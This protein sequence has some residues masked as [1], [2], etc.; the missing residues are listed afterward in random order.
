MRIQFE[1][2]SE[3]SKYDKVIY[4]DEINTSD[5]TSDDRKQLLSFYSKLFDNDD[6]NMYVKSKAIDV[7]QRLYSDGIF[8]SR[9][10]LRF[11]LDDWENSDELLE[12][13][14]LKKLAFYYEYSKAEII[15]AIDNDTKVEATEI[16]SEANYQLGIIY[17]ISSREEISNE[18][19]NAVLD[20]AE[21]HFHNSYRLTE[22]RTDANAFLNIINSLKCLFRG[23]EQE[24]FKY[25]NELERIVISR[26]SAS[27]VE[28]DYVEFKILV[29]LK[30]VSKL[31]KI[32][33]EYWVDYKK[34]LD[35]LYISFN[36]FRKIESY[37]E[38]IINTLSTKIV[39]GP[40][41]TK[42]R[43]TFSEQKIRIDRLVDESESV[44]VKDFL[45]YIQSSI[46]KKNDDS[47]ISSLKELVRCFPGTVEEEFE[48]ALNRFKDEENVEP[49]IDLVSKNKM[50]HKTLLASI[51]YGLST[52]NGNTT[53]KGATEDEMNKQIASIL[54]V[55]GFRAKDQT[56]HGYSPTGLAFGEIDIQIVSGIGLPMTVIEGLILTY[57]D[58]KTLSEHIDKTFIYDD[59]GVNANYLV[60]Y[61]RGNNFSSFIDRYGEF[62]EEHDYKYNLKTVEKSTE[63]SYTNMIVLKAVHKREAC[64]VCLYHVIVDLKM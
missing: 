54:E 44:D 48:E 9:D 40:L 61:Y 56:Q 8:K 39:Q 37:Y 25:V 36:E 35:E 45:K 12:V 32:N 19:F 16:A 7:I 3:L 51:L 29:L 15:E 62:I 47:K 31:F 53:F 20:K 1:E 14:R 6:I 60:V 63:F 17:L 22:N 33:I 27:F 21:D 59:L 52:I 43:S 34:E 30:E 4:F 38:G 41:A 23:L 24:F 49:L 11:L 46:D 58:S 13:K 5:Y 26:I 42:F 64:D 55:K 57:I 28:V 18:A 50:N 10:I 2:F